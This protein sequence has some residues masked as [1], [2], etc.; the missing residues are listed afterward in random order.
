MI[1]QGNGGNCSHIADNKLTNCRYTN[2]KMVLGRGKTRYYDVE[3]P[4]RS[5]GQ[6]RSSSYGIRYRNDQTTLEIPGRY[7][8]SNYDD[9]VHD[10]RARIF[11]YEPRDCV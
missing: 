9:I 6:S 10:R 1:D 11:D 4:G 8:R 2:G 7:N 5:F 3:V